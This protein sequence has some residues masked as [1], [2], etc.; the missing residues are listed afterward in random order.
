MAE[1]KNSDLFCSGQ[2]CDESKSIG[3]HTTLPLLS[4]ETPRTSFTPEWTLGS[5]SHSWV[6]C[7]LFILIIEPCVYPIK[8]NEF[9]LSLQTVKIFLH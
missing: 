7:S 3:R 8:C 6:C 5:L 4:S 9:G 2:V 1:R